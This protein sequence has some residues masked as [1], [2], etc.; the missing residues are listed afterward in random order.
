MTMASYRALVLLVTLFLSL[1]SSAEAQTAP[2][3]PAIILV[4]GAFHK[5]SVYDQVRQLLNEVDYNMIDAIDLPSV[6]SLASYVDREPD[7]VAVRLAL[8]AR[9]VQGHN[10]VLVGNSYGATVIG[11]VV[12]GLQSVGKLASGPSTPGRILGLI[13]VGRDF[14]TLRCRS[15]AFFCF[16][17]LHEKRRTP[18]IP[19]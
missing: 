7:V 14:P 6:G 5:A 12:S 15:P 1:F 4:P 8:L 17:T 11:E 16:T 3:K 19:C 13:M 18:R 2:D 10:V 9:L